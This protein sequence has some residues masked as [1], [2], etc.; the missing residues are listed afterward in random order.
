MIGAEIN[1]ILVSLQFQD[2]VTQMLNASCRN[3][4]FLSAYINE[5]TNAGTNKIDDIVIDTEHVMIEQHAAY[6]T[7]ADTP[8]STD[9]IT[10]F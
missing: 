10:Y 7:N 4:E 2:R 8:G 6:G 3:I 1:T 5:V 9:E